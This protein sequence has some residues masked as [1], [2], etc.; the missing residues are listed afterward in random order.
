MSFSLFAHAAVVS[1]HSIL[2]KSHHLREMV[3]SDE[4]IQRISQGRAMIFS[5]EFVYIDEPWILTW[6]WI[7]KIIVYLGMHVTI[8]SPLFCLLWGGQLIAVHL[9]PLFSPLLPAQSAV[10]GCAICHV[11]RDLHRLCGVAPL[12]CADALP[13]HEH[14]S[15]RICRDVASPL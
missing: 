7:A 9:L 12:R 4:A 5:E 14:L 6:A 2:E 10:F 3:K 1:P 11:D 15:V 13:L 8:L